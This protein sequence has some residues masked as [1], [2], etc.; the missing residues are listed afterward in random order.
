MLSSSENV[1]LYSNGL[2][3]SSVYL[4]ANFIAT[5]KTDDAPNY[6]MYIKIQIIKCFS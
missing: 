1:D 4:T 2:L 6:Y 5:K 3:F